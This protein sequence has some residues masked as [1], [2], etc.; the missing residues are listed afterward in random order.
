MILIVSSVL[1]QTTIKNF[2]DNM[3]DKIPNVPRALLTIRKFEG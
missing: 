2:M 3:I 1:F